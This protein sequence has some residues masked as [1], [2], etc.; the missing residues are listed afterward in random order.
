MSG[1]TAGAS[2]TPALSL[3]HQRVAPVFGRLYL[4]PKLQ[5]F[6]A[7]YPDIDLEL[8]TAPDLEDLIARG[9]DIAIHNGP[10]SD[11][12][13]IARKI[14]SVPVVMV[15]TPSYLEQNGIPTDLSHLEQ[16][17]CIVFASHGEP[18]S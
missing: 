10:L 1:H 3:D 14:A 9:L 2:D 18:F 5:E 17:N 8:R 6:F 15:A 12:S 11:S 13:L 7:Q 4:I 16:H